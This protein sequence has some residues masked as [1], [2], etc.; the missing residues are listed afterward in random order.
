MSF[1]NSDWRAVLDPDSKEYYYWNTLTNETTW[2]N[3]FEKE[4]TNSTTT[5][6]PSEYQEY[7]AQGHFNK[8]TGKFTSDTSEFN[9][10][11]GTESAKYTRTVSE[12]FD[13]NTWANNRGEEGQME[14]RRK[15]PQ[16]LTRRQL[17]YFK[18]KKKEKLKKKR[19]WLFDDDHINR[20][21]DR[22]H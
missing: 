3:P 18:Q 1:Q 4:E 15:G 9:P 13:Y 8:K 10:R 22:T 17:D 11:N 20:R 2:K 14:E 12:H 7:I 16:N 19:S 6:V 21:R 5:T